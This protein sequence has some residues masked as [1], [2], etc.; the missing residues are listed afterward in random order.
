M[1]YHLKRATIASAILFTFNTYAS[2]TVLPTIEV[3]GDREQ[4]N[5]DL[6]APS[7]TG[8]RLKLSTRDT[9]ASVESVDEE[10]MRERGD[11]SVR[12]AITR[13]TGL[14][15]IATQGDGGVAYSARGFTGNNSVAVLLDGRQMM[16]GAGTVTDPSN[17]WGYGRIEVLRGP[18]SI[19]YGTGA[20]GATINAI[21]KAPLAESTGEALIGIGEGNTYR[22]GLGGTGALGSAGAFR[23]D[24]YTEGSDGF[25]DRGDSKANKL[26]TSFR[27]D[28]R[29]D[30]RIEVQLDHADQNPTR[31]WGMPLINGAIDDSIRRRNYNVGDAKIRYV[32]DRLLGRVTWEAASNLTVRDEVTYFT[33]KRHWRDA[34]EYAYNSLT[35]QVDRASF[36]EIRHW[37]QQVANRLEAAYK[38]KGNRFVAGWEISEFDFHH[39]SNGF[40]GSD[41]VPLQNFDSGSFAPQGIPAIPNFS[42]HTRGLA[43]YAEDA[44]DMTERLL[45]LAGVRYDNYDYTRITSSTGASF[46]TDLD[47]TAVRLGLTYRLTPNTSIYAQASTGSDPIGSLLSISLANSRFELTK[48]R[49]VEAGL[50][51]SFAGGRGEWT[52]AFYHI[53]KD[54]IITRDPNNLALS[55]QGGSQSSKGA[56]FST[57][58]VVGKGWRIDGNVALLDAQFD[59]LTDGTGTSFAGKR[60]PNVANQV[61]NLWLNYDK[62]AWQSGIGARYV[63]KSYADNGNTQALPAYTVVDASVAWHKGRNTTFRAIV[64]NL[65]DRVYATTAYTSTQVSLGD[66]RHV[67]LTAEFKF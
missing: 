14:T 27:L 19:L 9:P 30:L 48:G 18:G 58:F 10:T 66:P 54:D 8:S 51:Q 38:T 4:P 60:P 5:L 44:Y 59:E 46:D 22:V 53:K 16:V 57:S 40:G 20:T 35:N 2:D 28:P 13:T 55:I 26:M 21:R 25:I 23:I 3:D 41:S 43:F 62:R 24:A 67:E 42:S 45:L 33:A 1:Y 61:A 56:E 65:G 11:F 31:Y 63:G 39:Y 37:Q 50:K 15:D 64:R 52:T 7:S 49:Q 29:S 47:S 17:T 6:N 12:D 34:E 32:D 36:G